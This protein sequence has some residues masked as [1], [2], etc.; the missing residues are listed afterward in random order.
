MTLIKVT[1]PTAE[2]AEGGGAAAAAAAAAPAAATNG[3]RGPI[4]AADGQDDD[5]EREREPL[6]DVRTT[7][8][9]RRDFIF[10]RMTLGKL[11]WGHF[12]IPCTA[13]HSRKPF[14]P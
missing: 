12:G 5:D 7:K 9:V 14:K 8:E 3:F 11:K 4:S 2:E 6:L 1:S 10:Y 13:V